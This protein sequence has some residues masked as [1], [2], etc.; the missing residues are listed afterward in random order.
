MTTTATWFA[1]AIGG[2]CGALLRFV[3]NSFVNN[4]MEKP[5]PYGVLTVNVLGSF[6]IGLFMAYFMEHDLH[7]TAIARGIVVGFLGAFTTFSTFSL[8]TLLLIE[9]GR[10]MLASLNIV[11]NVVLCLFAVWLGMWLARFF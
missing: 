10:W 6:L 7:S 3:T 2:A 8:D 11:S 1:I 9:Q 5:F 4:L